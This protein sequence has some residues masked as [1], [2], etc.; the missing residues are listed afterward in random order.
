MPDDPPERLWASTRKNLTDL[1]GAALFVGVISAGLTWLGAWYWRFELIANLRSAIAA[2]LIAGV[3]LFLALREWR[4][5]LALSVG[6]VLAGGPVAA[7]LLTAS[8][9]EVAGE[10]LRLVSANVLRNRYATEATAAEV[11]AADPDVIVLLEV[12]HKWLTAMDAALTDYP[13]RIQKPRSDN[14]GIAVY[15][16][17]PFVSNATPE[18][19]SSV[20][21]TIEV[22]LDLPGGPVTLSAVHP[23]PPVSEGHA[24]MRDKKLMALAARTA[25]CGRCIVAGDLNITPYSPA[26]TPFIEASG[27]SSA[28]GGR[29]QGTWPA[30]LPAPLLIALDHVL[31]G[32][33]IGVERLTVGEKTGSDHLPLIVDLWIPGP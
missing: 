4:W 28:R 20:P 14:F 1:L 29:L 17:V 25:G 12:D 19:L 3:L 32:P 15:S 26:W 8:H 10:P 18:L 23:P 30:G 6:V 2:A 27:L 24:E 16:R 21:P 13:H 33:Q 22:D 9:T 31:V 7:G 5:A 11:L